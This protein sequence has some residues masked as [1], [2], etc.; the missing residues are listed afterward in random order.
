VIAMPHDHTERLLLRAPVPGDLP[1]YRE[2]FLA[3]EVA[4]WMRPPPLEPLAQDFPQQALDRDVASHAEHGFGPWAVIERA[5]AA[6]AGRAGL[7]PTTVDGRPAVQ[8][9]WAIGPTYQGKGY[10]TEVALAAVAEAR[11]LGLPELV[12]VTLARNA[13][14]R[15]VME[16]AGLR[17]DREVEHAGLPHVRYRLRLT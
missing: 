16:K 2:L 15:R 9:L 5:T 8:L 4:A 17:L 3:P 11:R 13:A 1:A 7:D 10:A 14:S 12:S 6:Y